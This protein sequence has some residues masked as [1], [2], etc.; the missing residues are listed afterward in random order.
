MSEISPVRITIPGGGKSDKNKILF[1]SKCIIGAPARIS[2]IYIVSM[3]LS[4]WVMSV[5]L[6]MDVPV[7][8]QGVRWYVNTL[9][10][11]QLGEGW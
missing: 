7:W 8:L 4:G 11:K 9:S 1:H 3:S 2:G 10:I 5:S 6:S